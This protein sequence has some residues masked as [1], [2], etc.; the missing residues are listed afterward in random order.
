MARLRVM[1][2]ASACIAAFACD[3]VHVEDPTQVALAD[4]EDTFETAYCE[5]M[6][7]CTCDQGRYFEHMSDC[8]ASLGYEADALRD[9]PPVAGIVYDPFCV[10]ERVDALDE[11][12]CAAELDDEVAG[13]TRP[14]RILH[15]ERAEGQSCTT[16]T[17][18][19]YSDCGKRLRCDVQECNDD[20]CTGV[21]ADPC[22]P[23]SDEGCGG[24]G[25]LSYCDYEI[26]E[27]RPLPEEGKPCGSG[28]YCAE[29]LLCV[30][31]PVDPTI[32]L[33]TARGELG[34]ACSG[35][36]QCESGYCPAGACTSLPGRGESCVGTRACDD[37][38]QCDVTSNL[39]V[40]G[41]A[42]VCTISSGLQPY[43]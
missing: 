3:P 19:N 28:S 42:L 29:D 2:I 16:T 33:C 37:G 10:G 5:R 14:C 34:A 27:C 4:I 35:H 1:A 15:G 17:D 25:A 43:Y 13:C 39:C 6:F 36:N 11:L 24:C 38:L 7:A 40:D 20:R 22:A 8:A 21:C 41:D 31:D 9:Q 30:T 12:G 23:S 18:G 32:A 26:N